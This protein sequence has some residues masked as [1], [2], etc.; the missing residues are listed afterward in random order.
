MAEARLCERF[1]SNYKDVDKAISKGEVVEWFLRMVQKETWN[2]ATEGVL[3]KGP[4][5]QVKLLSECNPPCS[6]GD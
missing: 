4:T 6:P 2:L 3:A 5:L 1:F